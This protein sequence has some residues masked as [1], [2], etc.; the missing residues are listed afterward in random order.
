MLVVV[1]AGHIAYFNGTLFEGATPESLAMSQDITTS[2]DG[3]EFDIAVLQPGKAP[4]V[5]MNGGTLPLSEALGNYPTLMYIEPP[6]SS[7][8]RVLIGVIREFLAPDRPIQGR[9]EA[10]IIVQPSNPV[11]TVQYRELPPPKTFF[12]PEGISSGESKDKWQHALRDQL[13]PLLDVFD[14]SQT[15]NP[16]V[17]FRLL[18]VTPQGRFFGMERARQPGMGQVGTVGASFIRGK[19]LLDQHSETLEKRFG[20]RAP[21]LTL[22]PL[23]AATNM[24]DEYFHYVDLTFL[25]VSKEAKLPRAKDSQLRNVDPS[26]LGVSEADGSEG[27]NHFGFNEMMHLHKSKQLFKPVANAFEALARRVCVQWIATSSAATWSTPDLLG[28]TT[29]QI[30]INVKL[31]DLVTFIYEAES[32]GMSSPPFFESA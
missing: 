11:R 10:I 20:S 28:V 13:G 29:L 14:E 2:C 16:N 32:S 12:L 21:R 26:R 4:D 25:A 6:G 22:G 7:A 5:S 1:A 19:S 9:N 18:I 23:L 17:G 31:E 24:L 27:R 3:H 30:D 8:G 15:Q